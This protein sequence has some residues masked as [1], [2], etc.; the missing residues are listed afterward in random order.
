MF[1]IIVGSNLDSC[2]KS[3]KAGKKEHSATLKGN[4]TRKC[5]LFEKRFDWHPFQPTYDMKI[6]YLELTTT[7]Q[8]KYIQAEINYSARVVNHLFDAQG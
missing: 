4:V 1:C 8:I 6:V 2:I 3:R 7:D 5:A